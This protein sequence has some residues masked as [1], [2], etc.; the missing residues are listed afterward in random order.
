MVTSVSPVA[1]SL[2]FTSREASVL[3]LLTFMLRARRY[4]SSPRSNSSTTEHSSPGGAPKLTTPSLLSLTTE[5]ALP[6]S[7]QVT[8][9]RMVV[10][11]VPLFPTMATTPSGNSMRASRNLR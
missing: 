5:E 8:A 7:A 6:K 11:P 4:E 3:R 2:P 1:S 9:S 10:L